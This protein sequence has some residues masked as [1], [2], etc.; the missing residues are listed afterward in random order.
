MREAIPG[1]VIG[2]RYRLDEALGRGGFGVV[3]RARDLE[4]GAGVAVKEVHLPDSD[5]PQERASRP[6]RARREARDAASLREH[7][8]IVPVYD[9]VTEDDR[10]WMVMRLVQGR[11]MAQRLADRGPLTPAEAI[12]AAR[13]LLSALEA[14]HAAGI[15]HRDVKPANAM[16]TD[17]GDI[18]LTD[19]GIARVKGAGPRGLVTIQDVCAAEGRGAATKSPPARRRATPGSGGCCSSGS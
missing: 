15:V 16:T 14:A 5:W 4:L 8:H 11:S 10:P 17:R 1:A 3:R 19:F 13:C 9:L 2:G 6:A 18:L 7:P 12:S